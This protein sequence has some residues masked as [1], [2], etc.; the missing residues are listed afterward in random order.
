[1]DEMELVNG[2]PAAKTQGSRWPSAWAMT[3]PPRSATDG[4]AWWWDETIATVRR[5]AVQ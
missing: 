2:R 5:Q 1:M 3:G 4:A